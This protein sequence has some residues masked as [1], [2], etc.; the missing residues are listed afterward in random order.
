MITPSTLLS[1]TPIVRHDWDTGVRWKPNN[2]DSSYSMDV[3]LRTALMRSMN[4]PTIDLFERGRAKG[5]RMGRDARDQ[6]KAARRRIDRAG[7]SLRDPVGA[8]PG[9]Q[10]VC[11]SRSHASVALITRASPMQTGRSYAIKPTTATSGRAEPIAGS[12]GA[13]GGRLNRAHHLAC[14]VLRHDLSSAAGG[15]AGNRHV[16]GSTGSR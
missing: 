16:R 7:E 15:R 10:P 5:G 4:L 13:R 3:P 6:T 2:Y 9:L 12:A 11:A 14:A 1:D 8:D